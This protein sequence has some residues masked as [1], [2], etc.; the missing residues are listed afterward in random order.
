MLLVL[1]AV[2]L[3]KGNLGATVYSMQ[4]PRDKLMHGFPFMQALKWLNY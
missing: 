4:V 3:F 2:Q 1:Y